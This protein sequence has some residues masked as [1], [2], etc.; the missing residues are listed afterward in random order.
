M[1]KTVN[2]NLGGYPFH[3][4]E[5]AFER[6]K[7]YIDKLNRVLSGDENKKEIVDDIE[8]RIAELFRQRLNQY[9]QVIN[10][11]DVE[12]VIATLGS[13]EDIG[14]EGDTET[15][16]RRSNHESS[17]RKLYRD[18]DARILGGVCSGLAIYA[19]IPLWLV[20]VLFVAFTFLGGFALLVYIILWIVVPEAKTTSQRIEMEGRPVNIG[21][22]T[23]FVKQ[24][25]NTVKKKMNL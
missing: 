8:S 18:P 20:R 1:K 19:S 9:K 2:I 14:G 21:N 5:D 11:R 13:P 12:D 24:E 25:F 23:D 7:E 22:I 4:D 15:E 3:V 16:G 6:L 17:T 10:L